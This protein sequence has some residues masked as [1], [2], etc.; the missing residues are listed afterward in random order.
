MAEIIDYGS[1]CMKEYAEQLIAG[2]RKPKVCFRFKVLHSERQ[3]DFSSPYSDQLSQYSD[4]IANQTVNCAM[5]TKKYSGSF[6]L[7]LED[8]ICNKVLD[9]VRNLN[10][11]NNYFIVELLDGDGTTLSTVYLENCNINTI[12]SELDYGKNSTHHF[13]LV[14]DVGNVQYL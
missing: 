13:S 2:I 1:E 5:V 9:Y 6:T 8:D 11:L 12:S 14:F 10:N 3:I 7:T 4:I